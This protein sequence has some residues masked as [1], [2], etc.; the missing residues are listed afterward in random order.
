MTIQ[1]H[2]LN[3]RGNLDAV[4]ERVEIAFSH[5][6]ETL[7]GL[8]PIANV[9]VIVQANA[10]V[11][12]ET[13]MAGYSPWADALY[14]T[15]DPAN[16]NLFRDFDTEFLATLGHELHHCMRH[17]GPGYGRTLGEALVSEGLACHFETEL[18]GG[19]APFY[20]RALDVGTLEAM[21]ARAHAERNSSYK[22]R[23]WFFGSSEDGIPKYTGYSVGFSI[24]AQY[25]HN[26]GT[27]ASR[28]WDAPAEAFYRVS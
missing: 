21:R 16:P 8:L 9:D 24:V 19:I 5:G 18:R 20:A 28:L 14:I 10:I 1:L 25:I 3:A 4:R 22:H 12:P 7:A 27:P 17:G 2:L 15:I 11:V 6:V 26:C 23:A 13:G